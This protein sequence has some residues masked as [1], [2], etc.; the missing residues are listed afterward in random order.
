MTTIKVP[1]QLRQRVADGAAREGLTAADLISTLLDE[2]ERRRRFDAV[3]QAYAADDPTYIEET[4][5]WDAAIGDGLG[6]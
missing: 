3:R 2:Y 5:V 1:K 6:A 4:E